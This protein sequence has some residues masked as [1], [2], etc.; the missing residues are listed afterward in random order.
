MT[1]RE[2]VYAR[3][4]KLGRKR[5]DPTLDNTFMDWAQVNWHLRDQDQFIVTQAVAGNP[6]YGYIEVPQF[7]HLVEYLYDKNR[8]VY[9]VT[10][11]GRDR[12]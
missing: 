9:E 2:K 1:T 12:E 4:L 8:E 3:C 5:F 6:D 10:I 7:V 11:K